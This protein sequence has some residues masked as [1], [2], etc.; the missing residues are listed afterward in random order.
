MGN[1]DGYRLLIQRIGCLTGG[2]SCWPRR[3]R[4]G[5]GAKCSLTKIKSVTA[6]KLWWDS[7]SPVS[8]MS[9]K[10]ES[11]VMHRL[12]LWMPRRAWN[13][14]FQLSNLP[15]YTDVRK[16]DTVHIQS[17]L[18]VVNRSKG[19]YKKSLHKI[20]DLSSCYYLATEV[21][22]CKQCNRAF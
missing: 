5:L 17:F 9:P 18:F 4:S 8:T 13:V 14:T 19:L 7:P 10:P 15:P 2:R 6:S 20:I 16:I 11:Y 22:N 21:L 1:R 3:S 12:C